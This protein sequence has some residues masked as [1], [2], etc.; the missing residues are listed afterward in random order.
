MLDIG[1]LLQYT[2]RVALKNE[3]I[4]SNIDGFNGR[5]TETKVVSGEKHKA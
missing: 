4:V 5:G 1:H 3:F 2:S